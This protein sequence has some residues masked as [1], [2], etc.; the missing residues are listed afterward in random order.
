MHEIHRLLGK[1]GK[2][3]GPKAAASII[4]ASGSHLT[5]VAVTKKYE[6][7]QDH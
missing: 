4:G 2:R 5:V 1:T 7:E 6:R 3:N